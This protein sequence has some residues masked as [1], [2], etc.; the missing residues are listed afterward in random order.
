MKRILALLLVAACLTALTASA[1]AYSSFDQFMAAQGRLPGVEYGRIR[2]DTQR[3]IKLSFEIGSKSFRGVLARGKK[4]NDARTDEII[5][6]VMKFHDL[7]TAKLYGLRS[8][9]AAA[10]AQREPFDA[11]F[12]L[13]AAGQ[14]LH[15]N[16]LVK[17]VDTYQGKMTGA[18]Y[19]VQYIQSKPVDMI[20]D[21][22][23]AA[24]GLTGLPA[25]IATGLVGV[26]NSTLNE[27][28]YMG[29]Y[30]EI[31][32]KALDA[33][34][35]LDQFY[36][37]CNALIQKEADKE[38]DKW[39]LTAY[40]SPDRE[41]RVLFGANVKQLWSFSCSL[42]KE[43]GGNGP[44]EFWGDYIGVM[45]VDI[46]HEMRD[47]DTNFLWKVA[48]EL[49]VMPELRDRNPM[50][51][52]YDSCSAPTTLTKSFAA[53]QLRLYIPPNVKDAK[54]DSL[55]TSIDL[56]QFQTKSGFWCYHTVWMV[57]DGVVPFLDSEGKY[58]FDASSAHLEGQAGTEIF[59][60]G[61]MPDGLCPE[62]FVKSSKMHLWDDMTAP[63]AHDHWDKSLVNDGDTMRT[64]TDIF[65]DLESGK[66][67]VRAGWRGDQS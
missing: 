23:V 65:R 38:D 32:Q 57:P 48:N 27:F 47:F 29:R 19:C 28:V 33:A 66:I 12:W 46:T 40:Q 44:D 50:H 58:Q 43:S 13:E 3:A 45:T 37:D 59:L 52:F 54:K 2:Q 56:G 41:D 1:F 22:G 24:A 60:M 9:I 42:E 36:V 49:P 30:S 10:K 39:R 21:A 11:D 31:N 20:V 51:S 35:K 61:Q 4:L 64:N 25:F 5:K 63:Q 67:L 15:L 53:G 18:D 7:T 34:L 16:N 14:L 55:I 6:E 17:A 26:G 8:D 62:I